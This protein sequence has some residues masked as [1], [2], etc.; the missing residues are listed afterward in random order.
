MTTWP[1]PWVFIA[2]FLPPTLFSIVI[3]SKMSMRRTTN[4]DYEKNTRT[5]YR[6]IP[7]LHPP[8]PSAQS[9]PP[10]REPFPPETSLRSPSEMRL[11]RALSP[12]NQEIRQPISRI[13]F[14]YRSDPERHLRG[15]SL[16][17]GHQG[18]AGDHRQNP[19]LFPPRPRSR[20]CSP[21]DSD[22][23]DNESTSSL[24]DRGNSFGPSTTPLRLRG[25]R[26]QVSPINH[27]GR[28]NRG[29]GHQPGPRPGHD[30]S[31]AQ[32][33]IGNDGHRYIRQD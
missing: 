29:R 25:G 7:Q 6:T 10:L 30:Q 3:T 16:Q 20:P 23:S 13:I 33:F 18:K 1:L 4:Y 27:A 28:Q 5:W 31:T 11:E 14:E 12:I 9:P 24:S 2:L 19:I 26:K 22:S 17:D 8:T 15:N 21:F 32:V